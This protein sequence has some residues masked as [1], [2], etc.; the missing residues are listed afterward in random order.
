MAA[1]TFKIEGLKELQDSLDKLGEV[2]QRHVTAA[3]KKAMKIP[4]VQAKDDAPYLTGALSDGIIQKPEKTKDKGKKI[5]RIVF[6]RAMNDI[7]QKPVKNPGESGSPNASARSSAYYPVSQEYGFYTRDGTYIKG[8]AFVRNALES[9][10]QAVGKT[11]VDTM[12]IKIDDEIAK[13][14][15]K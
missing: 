7:F 3:S 5:Y 6:D 12:K 2:P 14:G 11:I 10:A 9:N 8:L 13:R 4:L 15:L 1:A